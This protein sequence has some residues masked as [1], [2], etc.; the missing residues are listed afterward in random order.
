ML[1]N[2]SALFVASCYSQPRIVEWLLRRGADREAACYLKQ[3]ALQV[4]GE[5]CE[6]A[7]TLSAG[8]SSDRRRVAAASAECRR[9]LEAPPSLP[10]APS[11]S[12][13]VFVSEYST[14]VVR[15]A[16]PA[17]SA[18]PSSRVVTAKDATRNG[19]DPPSPSPSPTRSSSSRASNGARF[20]QQKVYSCLVT[21]TWD[22]P[23]S[24][25]AII[26]KYELRYRASTAPSTRGGDGGEEKL[27][28]LSSEEEA[29]VGWRMER[30][31]HN[32]KK[33]TQ[34]VVLAGCLQFNTLYE[35]ALRSWNSVGKG[36]WGEVFMVQTG[37]SPE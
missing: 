8:L 7:P 3:T 32:R 20:V 10:S 34:R 18:T 5:C 6:H 23:D 30:T 33:R 13:V 26:D 36:V 14:E 28:L 24:N 4:V 35:C 9:L 25:G 2:A 27:Q 37:A 12:T 17:S 21:V 29:D 15:V 19:N 22:T 1:Q 31:T 16:A 11:A